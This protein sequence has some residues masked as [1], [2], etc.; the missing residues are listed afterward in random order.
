[1]SSR[2]RS[3][4]R[5]VAIV[6][7]IVSVLLFVLRPWAPSPVTTSDAIDKPNDP[8]TPTPNQQYPQIADSDIELSI[9]N[10]CARAEQEDFSSA[11]MPGAE[12]RLAQIAEYKDSVRGVK[13]RL[14][15]SPDAEH[16]HA[17]ALLESEP[18]RR[19]ELMTKALANGR[20]DAFL[21]W[22]AVRICAKS[23]EQTGCPMQA[24]E[25]R[26]LVLD[27]QNSE[28]W[29]RVTANRLLA[30]DNQAALRALQQA[31]SASETRAYWTESIEMIERGFAAGSDYA[32][33]QRAA[34]A[35]GM[36]RS[37]QPEYLVYYNMCKEE[38]ARSYEWAY[39]CLA[40]AELVERQG[41]T[42]LG[43]MSARAIQKQALE[44]LGDNERLAAV[45]ARQE[46]VRRNRR[47]S[48]RT[49]HRLSE[50]LKV[51][52]PSIFFRLFG[53]REDRW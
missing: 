51:S 45:V 44:S 47:E 32:F 52:I 18:A 49:R 12:E 1:M 33:A 16:L 41:R 15:V 42:E 8:G 27:G 10:L 19:I 36:A 17:A 20:N 11:S 30:G 35:L 6:A 23:L 7:V 26:L 22:D 13:Q 53:R 4:H 9:A 34:F 28:A 37:N 29:V 25:D 21:V 2:H 48:V 39:A 38:S 5:A 43:Q 3:P 24:W 50:V 40:Y 14:I 46:Q 31:A